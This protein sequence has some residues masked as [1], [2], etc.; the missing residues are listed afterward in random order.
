LAFLRRLKLDGCPLLSEDDINK[1]SFHH[2]KEPRIPLLSIKELAARAVI[3]SEVG[4]KLHHL[5]PRV[6]H[7]LRSVKHCSFCQRPYFGAGV[8][9]NRIIEKND[10]KIP[11]EYLLCSPH[12]MDDTERVGLLFCAPENIHN[13]LKTTKP[14]HS[15]NR[16]Q[17]SSRMILTRLSGNLRNNSLSL[18]NTDVPLLAHALDK[19]PQLPLLP[20]NTSLVRGNVQATLSLHRR[21]FIN[22]RRSLSI[23]VP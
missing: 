18:P 21:S 12:W 5:P 6:T 19:T 22:S 4:V 2:S 15:R 14:L 17:S 11:L 7:Y 20:E 23:H 16:S 1:M 3:S 13:T 9:R 8:I 10:I